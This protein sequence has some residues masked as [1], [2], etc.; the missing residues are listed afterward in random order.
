MIAEGTRAAK[1]ERLKAAEA[2]WFAD[3]FWKLVGLN[4]RGPCFDLGG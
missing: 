2:G 4:L 3:S 1:D